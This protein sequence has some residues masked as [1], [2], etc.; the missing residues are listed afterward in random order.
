MGETKKR[1]TKK[2]IA[3]KVKKDEGNSGEVIAAKIRAGAKPRA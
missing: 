1:G 2:S 3:A